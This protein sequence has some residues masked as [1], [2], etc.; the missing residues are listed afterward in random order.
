MLQ[1]R[2]KC[3]KCGGNMSSVSFLLGMPVFKDP[4]TAS[5]PGK[6]KFQPSEFNSYPVRGTFCHDERCGYVEFYRIP[7]FQR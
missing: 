4:N 7:L 3:P 1:E 5:K 2:P 6:R